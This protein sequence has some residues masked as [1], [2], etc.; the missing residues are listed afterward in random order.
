MLRFSTLLEMNTAGSQRHGTSFQLPTG[1]LQA[2]AFKLYVDEV[3]PSMVG[4]HGA[5]G[6]RASRYN[7]SAPAITVNSRAAPDIKKLLEDKLGKGGTKLQMMDATLRPS[8]PHL[9]LLTCS[10]KAF[11]MKMAM[12]QTCSGLLHLCAISCQWTRYPGQLWHVKG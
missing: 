6:S 3:L 7:K 9:L 4:R 12:Q 1:F 5:G 2:E 8:R 10:D 11:A